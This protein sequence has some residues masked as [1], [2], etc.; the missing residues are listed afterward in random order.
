MNEKY[1]FK[2][3]YQPYIFLII[4]RLDFINGS[5]LTAPKIGQ[6]LVL[7]LKIVC[8]AL[9]SLHTY[10]IFSDEISQVL[11]LKPPQ[12]H[13][14]CP[15]MGFTRNFTRLNKWIFNLEKCEDM[16]MFKIELI[17]CL[18]SYNHDQYN[19]RAQSETCFK[20]SNEKEN[21]NK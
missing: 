8:F 9:T 1:K 12:M 20:L 14:F 15:S 3:S 5:L 4:T 2:Y 11:P 19:F 7:R 13:D 10:D 17:A 18:I 16:C 6:I 21:S